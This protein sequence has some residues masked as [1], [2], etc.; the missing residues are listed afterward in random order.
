MVLDAQRG[1]APGPERVTMDLEFADEGG[2][3]ATPY[4]VLLNAAMRGDAMR[5]SA[6]GRRRGAVAESSQPLLDAPPPCIR[7]RRG[8]GARTRAPS[9]RTASVAGTAVGGVM[10]AVD[11]APRR[12]RGRAPERGRALP[13]PADRVLRLPLELPHRR[14]RGAGR[15]H[16]VAV[17]AGL[18][19]AQ[20]VRDAARP[21]G[22]LL[23]DRAV[24]D[25]RPH[26]A[27]LRAGHEHAR[28]DVAHA[29]RLD[30]RPRRADDGPAHRRGHGHPAHAPAGRRRRRPHARPHRRVHRGQGRG[31]ARVRAGVRL[32]PHRGRV[33]APRTTATAPTRPARA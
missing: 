21:P 18:R 7:T 10:T 15:R 13:V 25:R 23:P 29:E 4:E 30:R 5:F 6:P 24:R 32:R 2:E 16:R 1:D 19:L 26:V 31:R 27:R 17:R 28:H 33:G 3:A 20:R 9:C 11:G 8:P 22:R 14:A 12:A